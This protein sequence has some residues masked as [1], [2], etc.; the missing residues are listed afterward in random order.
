MEKL[1]YEFELLRKLIKFNTDAIKKTYYKECA[2]VIKEE[3]EKIGLKVDI[4]DGGEEAKD[5]I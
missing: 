1:K 5:N 3:C 2:E 4:Y